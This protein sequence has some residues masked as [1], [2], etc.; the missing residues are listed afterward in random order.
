MADDSQLDIDKIKEETKTE[1][2]KAAQEA[3]ISKLQGDKP[4]YSWEE[5]GKD[6][7]SD[8]DELFSEVEKRFPSI[9][10]EEIDKRVE[11]RLKTERE[12]EAKAKEEEQT[13]QTQSQEEQRKTFDK[14]W[15]ELVEAKKMP[16]IAPELAERINKGETLTKEEIETDEGLKARLD[17]IQLAMSKKKSVKL[18]YYEDYQE[19]DKQP[20]GATAPVLG[21][22]TPANTDSQELKYE[23]VAENRKNIFGF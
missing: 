8:Y 21:G 15:Y 18:A 19:S 10:P 2:V 14:E 5:R 23:D 7:P 16:A 9:S 22:R 6:A 13:K 20:A 17:L 4:R 3:L 1:A 12:A 11:E